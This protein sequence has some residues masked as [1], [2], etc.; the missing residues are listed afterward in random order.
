MLAWWRYRYIAQEV[1]GSIPGPS[2]QHSFLGQV[3]HTK[4]Y[5]L[6][7]LPIGLWCPTT[8]KWKLTAVLA[9]SKV[10]PPSGLWVTSSVCWLS[11]STPTSWTRIGSDTVH[12]HWMS[13]QALHRL[14]S[15][16]LSSRGNGWRITVKA[17]QGRAGDNSST[18]FGCHANESDKLNLHDARAE[19][20][21]SPSP[22][23]AVAAAAVKHH[24]NVHAVQSRR[25]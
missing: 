5:V 11:R 20:C 22:T 21:P 1:M 24:G 18:G 15:V 13:L 17:S 4:Q 2:I 19:D 6:L 16:T 9:E 12:V 3:I 10:S 14:C 8:Q 23:A 7:L 25:N